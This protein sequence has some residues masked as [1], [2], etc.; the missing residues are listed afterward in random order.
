MLAVLILGVPL[1]V[2]ALDSQQIITLK[3]AGISDQTIQVL[4]QEKSVATGAFTVKEIIALKQAGLSAETIQLVI[5]EGSF[6]PSAGTIVYGHNTKPIALTSIEDI[7]ALQTAGFSD[8]VIQ[9]IIIY[10]TRD[11]GDQERAQ[12]R[13]L[14]QGMGIIVDKR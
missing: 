5:K 6:M 3:Q 14:L 13:E 1:G 12:A 9:A 10:G 8:P 2:L 11:P 4:M 7:K